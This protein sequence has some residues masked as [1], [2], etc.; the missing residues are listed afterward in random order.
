MNKKFQAL[1]C[2]K[3][4]ASTLNYSSSGQCQCTQSPRAHFFWVNMGKMWETTVAVRHDPWPSLSC[5][6]RLKTLLTLPSH[7][8]GVS[9]WESWQL[10]VWTAALLRH[11]KDTIRKEDGRSK[12]LMWDENIFKWWIHRGQ[13][14]IYWI[15]SEKMK[16]IHHL[17]IKKLQTF[18]IRTH[19][20]SALRTIKVPS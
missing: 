15:W 9:F 8:V 12:R 10:L 6:M 5:L 4:R 18:L 19:T 16:I 7:R 11:I 3:E 20:S 1:W 13:F 2:P 17:L 14:E